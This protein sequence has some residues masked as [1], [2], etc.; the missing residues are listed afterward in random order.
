MQSGL[1]APGSGL[2]SGLG[3]GSSPQGQGRRKE[4]L[5]V[6]PPGT[7]QWGGC[8]YLHPGACKFLGAQ[9][10]A[11]TPSHLSLPLPPAPDIKGGR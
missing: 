7:D 6:E 9:I 11:P 5:G 2:W 1:R 8:P 3:R 4:E 10:S